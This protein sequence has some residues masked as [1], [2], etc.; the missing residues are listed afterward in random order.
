MSSYSEGQTHQLMDKLE[1]E[2]F[3]PDDITLLGQSKQLPGILSVLHGFAEIVPIRYVLKR[4]P[5]DPVK[6][7]G[8]NWSIDEQ[9]GKRSGD[10]LDAGNIIGKAY[11]NEGETSINGEERLRR[12]KANPDDVQLDAEDF[13]ALWQEKGRKTLN[14]LYEIKGISW[15]SFWGTI[16]RLPDGD[17]IVLY[18]Y[19]YDDGSWYWYYY[20]VG[21]DGW[22]ARYPSG[23]LAS[24]N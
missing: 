24:S 2:G 14:M 18:L 1:A 3:T 23:V 21:L 4:L 5:F 7:I 11:L 15:L 20:L 13:L 22:N 8:N 9:V 16:L 19:R 6:F 12:I 17:R 10:S